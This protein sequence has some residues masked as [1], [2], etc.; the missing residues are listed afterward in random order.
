[1]AK[2]KRG[3]LLL[4]PRHDPERL[5][6]YLL[7]F[8]LPTQFGKH[9]WPPF[10]SVNGIR[11]DYLSPTLFTTDILIIVLFIFWLKRRINFNNPRPKKQQVFSFIIYTLRKHPL[12]L[13]VFVYLLIN[14]FLSYSLP[15]TSYGLIKIIELTFFGLYIARSVTTKKELSKITAIITLA[16]S[17]QSLLAIAQYIRQSSINGPLYYLGE[18]KFT[19]STPGI[20]NVSINGEL[21]LRPYGTFPHPN[22]LAGF[23]L[24]SLILTYM[25]IKPKNKPES[26]LKAS[27]ILLGSIALVLSLSRV[28]ISLWTILIIIESFKRV[29]KH[30]GHGSK[31]KHSPRSYGSQF[32][33]QKPSIL[34]AVAI[35]FYLIILFSTALTTPVVSR[36]LETNLAEKA[37]TQRQELIK[38]SLSIILARP[39]TGVGLYNFIPALNT[40]QESNSQTTNFQPVHNIFLLIASETGLIGLTLFS[41]IIFK[42]YKRLLNKTNPQQKTMLII[43]TT[44]FILGIFDHYWLTLQQT[45]LLFAL[46]LAISLT[47]ASR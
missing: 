22:V 27:A 5:T 18:R 47:H 12:W 11:I 26:T 16:I 33:N 39:L 8:L 44:I 20:A 31:E 28:A 21:L 3:L 9:F 38:D 40:I 17:L 13:T 15:L 7:I 36:L 19:A 14:T 4:S 45:Q 43:L 32:L 6:F 30:F 41:I 10:S 25:V 46:I 23:L 34:K 1:V 24:C 42:T 29:K 2:A 37:A 35:V